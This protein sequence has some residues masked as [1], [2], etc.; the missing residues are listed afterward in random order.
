MITSILCV[1]ND[2]MLYVK[3][4]MDYAYMSALHITRHICV[5]MVMCEHNVKKGNGSMRSEDI[6][7][8]VIGGADM[9]IYNMV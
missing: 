5:K 8:G 7:Y 4:G 6:H 1:M 3:C 2:A 9:M